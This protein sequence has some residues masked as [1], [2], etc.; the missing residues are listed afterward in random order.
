MGKG[1]RSRNARADEIIAD[2]VKFSKKKDVDKAKLAT[3]IGVA[4]CAF[5]LVACIALWGFTSW[6]PRILTVAK[7]DHFKV[8]GGEMTYFVNTLKNNYI[9]TVSQYGSTYLTQLGIDASDTSLTGLKSQKCALDSGKSWY[10]Y[11]LDQAK[12]QV[13]QMFVLCEAAKAE[14]MKLD[15]SEKES[16][17]ESIKSMKESAEELAKAYAENGYTGYSVSYFLTQQYG[18]GVSEGNVRKAMELSALSSKYLKA[19]EERIKADVT[20]EEIQKYFDANPAVFLTADVYSYSF[21]AVL[22]LKGSEA[23]EEEKAAYETAK[24]KAKKL[25]EELAACADKDAFI[26]KAVEYITGTYASEQFDSLYEAEKSKIAEDKRPTDEKLASDRNKILTSLVKKVKGEVDKLDKPATST[27]KDTYEYI[28]NK[29]CDELLEDVQGAY[30]AINE[31]SSVDYSDPADKEATDL[32]KWLFDSARKAG[33]KTMIKSEAEKKS[34]YTAYYL[35]A[36]AHRDDTVT[37]NVGHILFSTEK[38]EKAEEAKKKAEEILAQYKAGNQT[39]E[40]FEELA[41]QYTADG[42]VFYDNVNKGQ[43]VE[44]FEE[45]LFD[46]ARTV[47]EVG[48]VETTYGAHIMYFVGDG[49][50]AWKVTALDGVYG[51]KYDAWY[52]N[53]KK[54]AGVTFKN[55]AL[56]NLG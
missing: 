50:V 23:T 7:S 24:E 2:P 44:S 52:E 47:G 37:K 16:I 25:A 40:A 49:E 53:A 30:D 45:W 6:V 35:D 5:L 21:P 12:N 42:S 41:K 17:N 22:E 43:M 39:K 14:G 10:E 11:F 56:K 36:P 8:N 9:N 33:D 32:T 31:T 29:V 15:D 26:A 34:T 1:T 55:S 28:I 3:R 38:Y 51:E 19:Y 46:E 27:Q 13:E 20:D 18:N 4:V 48:I 54:E